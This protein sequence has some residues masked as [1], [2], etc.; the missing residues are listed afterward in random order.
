MHAIPALISDLATILVLAAITTLLC[1]KVNLPS[2]LG[3]ILAGFLVGPVV[4]IIPTIHDM[5][6]IEVWSDIGV[7][8]LMFG[9]GLEFSIHKMEEVGVSGFLSAGIQASGMGV[10]GFFLGILLGWDTMNS[11]FLGVML[12]MSSTMIT[13]KNIEDMGMKGEKFSSLA[14]GTLVIEDIIAIFAM[15]IL[16]TIAV[17]QSIS[18]WALAE[19][20]GLLL[21]YLAIWLIL[22]I[23]LVPTM[24]KKLVGLMNDEVLL[25]FSLGLCFLM[26]L[27]AAEIGLSTELGAFLAGSLLAGTVHAERV[28]HL[29]TPCKHLFGAVFFVSVGFM[30]QPAMIWQYLPVI[31][32]LS[33][34]AIVGKLVLLTL[35]GL[36]AGQELKVSLKAGASQTQ[37]GEF[38]FIIAGL[39]QSLSVTGPF[40]YPVIVAVSVLTTFTTPFVLKL[41]GMVGPWLEEK[42]PERWL[43]R[44]ER[45]CIVCKLEKPGED[46][47]WP[48]F[49]KS[50]FRSIA[51][52]G[53]LSVGTILL[54]VRHMRPFLRELLNQGDLW[55]DLTTCAVIYV[56]LAFLL[57]G[58]LRVKKRHFT[59][60]WLEKRSNRPPLVLLLLFRVGVA[61]LLLVAPAF[62]IFQ[63][64]PLWLALG[65]MPVIWVA[66]RSRLLA[67]RYL[68]VEARFLANYNERRLVEQFCQEEGNKE[69][70]MHHW[71]KEQLYVI[72]LVCSEAYQEEGRSLRQQNWGQVDHIKVIKILRGRE[73]MN[74]PEGHTRLRKGDRLTIMGSK[75]AV[76]NFA[77]KQRPKGLLPE[78]SAELVTL[79]EYIDHQETVA[80]S[81]QLLCYGVRMGKGMPQQGKRIR[82]SK[83]KEE[84][85]AFL[86]GLERDLLPI[87]N[88]DPNITLRT[89]DVLWVMGSQNMVSKLAGRNLLD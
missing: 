32:L 58:M 55:A 69:A 35:G 65:A 34:V 41:A 48:L 38:S 80:E 10:V 16:S 45:Y 39:G 81:K 54:G 62:L 8:F 6:G 14:M 22:G 85:G 67:G 3:Y 28:E 59:A 12:A 9:L 47:D 76:E 64:N 72:T 89:G 84:W 74:I 23:Y 5:E 82:D 66:T 21:L 33:V 63:V 17:S 1:K 7:I 20:I 13:M 79:K 50:F 78:R 42:L 86:F 88:P 31:L 40:L 60:L 24:M 30:V 25:V 18:G 83:I 46:K 73:H 68:E 4:D 15:V 75:R 44:L 71:L 52:Y 36:A 87:P 29:V 61:V 11:V 19:Q 70:E 26:A 37:V 51:L 53:V 27:L 49:L 77:M 2:V 57:A 43:D 56:L